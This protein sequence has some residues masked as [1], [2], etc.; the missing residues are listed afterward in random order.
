MRLGRPHRHF[1]VTDS[2]NS[3][4]R[5]LAAAS[6]P[7]GTVVTAAEQTAG[8]G[9]QGR[10]WTAPAGGALLYSAIVRP[11]ERR[12]ALLPLAAA[13]AVCETAEQLDDS[14]ECR[15]KWPNDIWVGE[16]KLAGILIEAR[17]QDGWAV[18]GIGLNIAISSEEFP[19]ELRDTATSLRST[20]RAEEARAALDARLGR[21]VDAEAGTV[22]SAW[23]ER[24]ALRGREISWDGGSGIADGVGESGDLLVLTAGGDRVALGA[25]EVHLTV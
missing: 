13:V 9:R 10:S 8:R 23:A 18:V 25:G 16:R 21:W 22:I 4:A 14:V 24:D 15:I 11:L 5:E 7:G 1:R 20:P 6:A 19:P 3:V 2:T 17:P 12:H